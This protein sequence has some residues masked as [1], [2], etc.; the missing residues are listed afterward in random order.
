VPTRSDTLDGATS[1]VALPPGSMVR[2]RSP[3]TTGTPLA[4]GHRCSKPS[5]APDPTT[6]RVTICTNIAHENGIGAMEMVLRWVVHDS[7]LKDGDRVI[8]GARNEEKLGENA[9]WI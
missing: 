8:F 6:R 7:P 5:V 9:G 3:A 4:H 1:L 2:P